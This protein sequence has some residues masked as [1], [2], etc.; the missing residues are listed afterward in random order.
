MTN[1]MSVSEAAEHLGISERQVRNYIKDGKLKAEKTNGKWCIDG[2]LEVTEGKP[3]EADHSDEIEWLR[4]QVEELQAELSET[5]QRSDTIILQLT[6]QLDK[7]TLML[8]D[9]RNRSLW[10]RIKMAVV[11]AGEPPATEQRGV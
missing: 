3:T 8:E 11:R 9:M 5:R 6:Q 1:W 10:C 2:S 7:Q 4:R